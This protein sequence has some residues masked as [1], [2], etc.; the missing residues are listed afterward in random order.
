MSFLKKGLIKKNTFWTLLFILI[1]LILVKDEILLGF[2]SEGSANIKFQILM[3]YLN[4]ISK[5]L[6]LF[7]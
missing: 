2:D 3:N 5:K 6:E 7:K 1:F 4:K